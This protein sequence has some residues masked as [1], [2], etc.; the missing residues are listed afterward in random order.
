MA[1]KPKMTKVRVLKALSGSD[2][3]FRKGAFASIPTTL[4]TQWVKAGL[5]ERVD[6][7]DMADFEALQSEHDKALTRIAELESQLKAKK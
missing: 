3:R 2:F 4:A 1:S 7:V 6:S 5:A